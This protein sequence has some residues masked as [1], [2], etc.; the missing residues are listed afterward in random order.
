MFP[1]VIQRTKN[2]FPLI[3]K[4]FLLQAGSQ[5]ISRVFHVLFES[6]TQAETPQFQLLRLALR[7]QSEPEGL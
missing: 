2:Y 1:A 6:Q 4:N 5:Q 7:V 3:L